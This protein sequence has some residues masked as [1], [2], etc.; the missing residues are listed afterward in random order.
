MVESQ[1]LDLTRREGI[2]HEERKEQM[3]STNP[4]FILRNH[5]IQFALDK[6]LKESDFSE[7]KRLRLIMENPFKD[8][9][10]IFEKY[11]IDAE[12][13]AQDTPDNFLCQQTSCSA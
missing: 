1:Y 5:L 9:P 13:Y 7:I 4:K 8:Q 6:A 2:S 11:G 10:E 12:H 3:D